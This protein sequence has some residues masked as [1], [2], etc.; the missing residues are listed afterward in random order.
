MRKKLVLIFILCSYFVFSQEK[1]EFNSTQTFEKIVNQFTK[2]SIKA[3]VFHFPN[4]ISN[5]FYDSIEN[6][7]VVKLIIQKSNGDISPKEFITAIDLNT[8]QRIW[9]NLFHT[10]HENYDLSDDL[11]VLMKDGNYYRLNSRS[12]EKLY[13]QRGYNFSLPEVKIPNFGL[14]HFSSQSYE[15]YNEE[16]FTR[17]DTK[18]GKLIWLSDK[19]FSTDFKIYNSFVK[20]NKL[21]FL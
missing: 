8:N 3:T 17:F 18:S 12:Q 6:I 20:G 15:T 1:S 21:Y 14:T 13:T 16:K 2:D 5:H 10:K 11:L 7:A 9:T 4:F 19:A